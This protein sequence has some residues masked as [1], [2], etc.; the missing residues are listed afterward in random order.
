MILVWLVLF[1]GYITCA[2]LIVPRSTIERYNAAPKDWQYWTAHLLFYSIPASWLFG[3][4]QS[5][6]LTVLGGML[7]FAAGGALN[8]WALVSNPYFLPSIE[9]PVRIA[10]GGAYSRFSHPGYTAMAMMAAGSWL[11]AGHSLAVI[12]LVVYVGLLAWRSRKESVLLT[13]QLE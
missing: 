4:G 11:M 1:V 12:P 8:I 9:V 3:D 13:T 6:L 5:L 10:R 2:A 7:L